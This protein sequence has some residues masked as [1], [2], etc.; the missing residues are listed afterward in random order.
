MFIVIRISFCESPCIKW[1]I[2]FLSCVK[3]VVL[4]SLRSD[5]A[6]HAVVTTLCLSF[7][8]KY[9]YEAEWRGLKF[10]AGEIFGGKNA[11]SSHMSFLG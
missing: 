10:E 5:A 9:V 4:S 11:E 1:L 8:A 6:A 7:Y 2:Y 3:I